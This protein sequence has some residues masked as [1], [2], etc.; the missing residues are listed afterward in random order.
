M[1]HS[2]SLA[3]K[4]VL[5]DYWSSFAAD[6]CQ[7]LL[8]K[9][10]YWGVP[11]VPPITAILRRFEPEASQDRSRW[12]RLS[13]FPTKRELLDLTF[14]VILG[15]GILARMDDIKVRSALEVHKPYSYQ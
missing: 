9:L 13:D 7:E 6:S 3:A 12:P 10:E 2:A 15:M 4:Y 11:F 5:V 8:P 1:D 14:P